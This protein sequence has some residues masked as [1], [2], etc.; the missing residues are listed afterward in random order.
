MGYEIR[1]AFEMPNS[2]LV[3]SAAVATGICDGVLA[4]QS[5]DVI[6]DTPAAMDGTPGGGLFVTEHV[7]T[8]AVFTVATV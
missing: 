1:A 2:L 5:S 8:G 3:T 7:F 4:H 6:T